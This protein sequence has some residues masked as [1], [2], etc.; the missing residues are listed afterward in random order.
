MNS[1][2]LRKNKIVSNNL[3]HKPKKLLKDILNNCYYYQTMKKQTNL[4]SYIQKILVLVKNY[5]ILDKKAVI[6][7]ITHIINQMLLQ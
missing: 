7:L 5:D 6:T 1:C 2:L 4:N 3:T